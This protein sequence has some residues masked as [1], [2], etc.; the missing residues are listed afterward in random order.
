M[1]FDI[2]TQLAA[3][4]RQAGLR[5]VQDG[6]DDVGVLLRRSYDAEIGDVW[7]AIT[8]PER[9]RRW[10]MPIS[11]DLRPG[12]SFQLH[13][14]AGG[15]ILECE[16]PHRLRVSFGGPTSIVEIRLTADDDATV[17]EL[18]HTVPLTIAQSV[19]GALF[20]GPGWDGALVGLDLYVRGEAPADPVE[21]A[22]SPEVIALNKESIAF[23]AQAA[24]AGGATDDEVAAGIAASTAQ[25]AP[26]E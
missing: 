19:A 23:W 5:P 10:F 1:M 4:Y 15:D 21:A 13:G 18:E 2:P 22:S 26:G 25:F 6:P 17:L 20:V 16:P 14:N 8:D 24:R 9:M 3:I 12:G 7:D 11:G